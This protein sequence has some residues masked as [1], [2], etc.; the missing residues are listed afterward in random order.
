MG[1]MAALRATARAALCIG[2]LFL[3]QPNQGRCGPQCSS[4]SSGEY[5]AGGVKTGT[6]ADFDDQ[7]DVIV[8]K[9]LIGGVVLAL[10]YAVLKRL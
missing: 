8:A 5:H 9:G 6:K 1:V 10:L 3:G 2:V 4:E 7:E